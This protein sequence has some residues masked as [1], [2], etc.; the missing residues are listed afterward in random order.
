MDYDFDSDD[1]WEDEPEDGEEIENSDGVK[2][3]ILNFMT[4]TLS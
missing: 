1:D 4:L 2:D 3:L